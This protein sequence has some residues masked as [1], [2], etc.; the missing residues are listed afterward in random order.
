[1][2]EP[3]SPNGAAFVEGSILDVDIGTS[4]LF[5][6]WNH[7]KPSKLIELRVHDEYFMKMSQSIH[8]IFVPVLRYRLTWIPCKSIPSENIDSVCI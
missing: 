2:V 8:D 3:N 7:L 6:R 1:M 5:L 4:I